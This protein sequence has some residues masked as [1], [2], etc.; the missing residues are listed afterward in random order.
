MSSHHLKELNTAIQCLG[1]KPK[2]INDS[3][4][5]DTER[6]WHIKLDI[7]KEN[8]SWKTK[9][10]TVISYANFNLP[11]CNGPHYVQTEPKDFR[12]DHTALI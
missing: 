5:K 11:S 1:I 10:T 12:N 4:I 3:C 2:A 8:G 6:N 7:K 9:K